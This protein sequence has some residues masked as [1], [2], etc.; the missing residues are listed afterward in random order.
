M[1]PKRRDIS[2]DDG[3][4]VE[5]KRQKMEGA[6]VPSTGKPTMQVKF[7]INHL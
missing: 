7:N 2:G 4:L 1:P 6:V 5:V 3:A